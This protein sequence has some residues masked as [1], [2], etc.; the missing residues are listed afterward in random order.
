[1]TNWQT[2]LEHVA[3]LPLLEKQAVAEFRKLEI[4]GIHYASEV[5]DKQVQTYILSVITDIQNKL[6]EKDVS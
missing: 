5:R 4:I 1:M 6:V 2:L 3:A